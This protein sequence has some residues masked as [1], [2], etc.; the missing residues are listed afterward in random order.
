MLRGNK[1]A[2]KDDY[3]K[4]EEKF[5]R[6]VEKDNQPPGFHSEYLPNI[7]PEG[8]VDFVLIG[9]E[10]ST[11]GNSKGY[12]SPKNFSGSVEDF[13]LHFCIKEY[14]YQGD[15]TY[16]LTDLSKGAM[17]VRVASKPDRTRRYEAWYPILRKEL[18]LVRK[19]RAPIIPIGREV[20]GFLSKKKTQQITCRVLHYSKNAAPHYPRMKTLYPEYYTRFESSVGWEHIE[21]TVK[22]IATEGKMPGD[23]VEGILGNLKGK[24]LTDSRKMLMFTYK[25]QFESIRKAAGL[26]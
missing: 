13:I 1:M 25:V 17:P 19:P 8:R 22:R 18:E 3:K 2:F 10:P 24:T 12:R 23:Y 9:S 21:Q 26:A 6:Q 16:Y 5:K 14:L 11:G 4:L 15:E 20:W 7:S